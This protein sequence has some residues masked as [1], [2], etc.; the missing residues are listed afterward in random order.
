MIAKKF[1]VCAGALESPRILL[2]SGFKNLNI[3]KYLM[4]HPMGNLCQIKFKRPQKSQIYSAIKYRSNIVIK[5]GLTL[6]EKLQKK[7]SIPNHCFYLRPSFSHGLDN[8]SERVKLSLLSFK[9]FK[10]S[11]KDVLF[12]LMNINIALQILVYKLSLNITYK[13]ADLF[14][15]SEQTPNETS[16]ITL[17]KSNNDIY[18]YPLAEINWKV[19][20]KDNESVE[21]FYKILKDQAFS[22]EDFEFTHKFEDLQWTNNFTSAAHHVGTCRMASKKAEG[23]VDKNLKVFGTNNLYVCDGSV[24]PT[25]GNVNNGYTIAALAS[26]LYNHLLNK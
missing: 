13:Y 22:L 20:S 12:V 17:S 21:K 4:D 18:G 5:T 10:F 25:G 8:K 24:F 7:Y 3:G 9:D 23:V 15:V 11:Y 19:S 26:R 16:S 6:D 2:N 14:F 1:I